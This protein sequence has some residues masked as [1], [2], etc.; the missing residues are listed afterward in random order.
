MEN[1]NSAPPIVRE[2]A[3]MV[4]G[5]IEEH[6]VLPDGSG[7]ATMSMPLPKNH[8]LTAD[9]DKC[10]DPPAPLRMGTGD[11]IIII[12]NGVTL[13][14]TRQEFSEMVRAAGRYAV[15]GATMNGR[16]IDFAPDALLQNLIVGMFGYHTPNGLSS[17]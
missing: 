15:R 7:F 12:I 4:G 13:H 8:W 11:K 17:L 6:G 9:Q 5:T 16:E 3:D 10:D 2:L 14:L 1:Q